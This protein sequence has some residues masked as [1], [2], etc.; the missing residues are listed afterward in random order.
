MSALTSCE[1]T[2]RRSLCERSATSSLMQCSKR[3]FLDR[4]SAQPSRAISRCTI[5]DRKRLAVVT[6]R[7]PGLG[8]FLLGQGAIGARVFSRI[9][10]GFWTVD[11]LAVI[12]ELKTHAGQVPVLPNRLVHPA[13]GTA[14]CG[15]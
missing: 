1:H 7:D 6:A 2:G 13:Q 9:K 3:H 8:I 15:S 11:P 5:G 12:E 14:V 10:R 4:L